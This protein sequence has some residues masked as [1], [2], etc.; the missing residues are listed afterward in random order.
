MTVIVTKAFASIAHEGQL[1]PTHY[2]VGDEL[3]DGSYPAEVALRNGWGE[4]AEAAPQE[5]DDERQ[6][7]EAAEAT[8]AKEAAEAAAAKEA[9]EAA[10]AAPANKAS[11]RAPATK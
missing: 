1:H 3:A 11:R 5:T 2:Q 8:A 10:A 6:R 9:A 4:A 7:R